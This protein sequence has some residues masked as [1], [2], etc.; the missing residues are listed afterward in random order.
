MRSEVSV[1]IIL[2]TYNRAALLPRS[3]ESVLGQTYGDFELIVVDDGSQDDSAAVVAKFGDKRTRYLR[4]TQN[5]GVAAARNTGLAEVR[6]AYVAFQDSDDQ[7]LPEKLERQ[8]RAFDRHPDAAVVYSDMHRIYSDGRVLYFRSPT[9]VRGRLINP[10]THFWQ[11]YML[12]MQPALVRRACFDGH[13]FDEGF[14]AFDDLDFY[15]RVAQRYEFLHMEE[16]LVKYFETDGLTSERRVELRD[17]RRLL[18]RYAVPLLRSDPAFLLKEAVDQ[19]L[20]RSLMPIVN[21]HLTPL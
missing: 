16:P 13:R 10:Q 19:L 12:A 3:I 17:R 21:L 11:S 7:W 4:H 2:P 1:S 5:R 6:G 14:G 8:K 15:L 20:R 18:R 9:I